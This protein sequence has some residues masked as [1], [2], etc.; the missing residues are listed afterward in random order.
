M[1]DM[2]SQRA[3]GIDIGERGFRIAA[4]RERGGSTV[5]EAWAALDRPLPCHDGSRWSPGLSEEIALALSVNRIRAGRAFVS[6]PD[7]LVTVSYRKLPPMPASEVQRALMWEM[8]R[9]MSVSADDAVMDHVSLGEAADVSGAMNAYLVAVAGKKPLLDLCRLLEAARIPPTALEFSALA[10]ITCLR[11]AGALAGTVAVIDLAAAHTNLLVARDGE[12][13][14]FRVIHAGGDHLTEAVAQATGASWAEAER[15]KTGAFPGDAGT[16][17]TARTVEGIVDEAYQTLRFYLAERKEG[18]V[19]RAVLT[20]GGS[21]LPGIREAF[22][23]VLGV[24]VEAADPFARL[25]LGP[26]ARDRE[27]AETLSARMVTA[28]GLALKE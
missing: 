17:L 10:Q 16:A 11:R 18:A 28:I 9:D 23:E 15:R 22:S 24:P 3:V 26:R 2:F 20:G 13:R 14:F 6:L 4:V 1:M 25:S 27:R 19:E 7:S 5:V 8:R 12:V 21:L